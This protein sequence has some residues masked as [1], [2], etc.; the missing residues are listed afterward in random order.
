MQHDSHEFL[1]HVLSQLQDEETPVSDK[2]FDGD[3]TPE[4]QHRTMEQI[5][6]EY[7]DCNPSLI[8]SLYTGI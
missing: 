8:D 1:M 3:V 2:K 5:Y 6:N 7:F 4:N